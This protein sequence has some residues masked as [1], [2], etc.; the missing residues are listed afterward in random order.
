MLPRVTPRVSPFASSEAG[1]S[2]YIQL[3]KMSTLSAS[4]PQFRYS[5]SRLLDT[6]RLNRLPPIPLPLLRRI[7]TASAASRLISNTHS[8]NSL[9]HF[10][11]HLSSDHYALPFSTANSTTQSSHPSSIQHIHHALPLDPLQAHQRESGQQQQAQCTHCYAPLS[12]PQK[13]L[14]KR[15]RCNLQ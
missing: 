7:I 15:H 8:T 9:Y 3:N 4:A 1:A 14:V 12:V 6:K 10:P 2:D 5:S 13:N 11:P